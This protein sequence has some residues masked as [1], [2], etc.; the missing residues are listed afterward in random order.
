[1]LYLRESLDSALAIPNIQW[2][3]LVTVSVGCKL[4]IQ[5]FSFVLF[6][7]YRSLFPAFLTAEARSQTPT[8]PWPGLEKNFDLSYS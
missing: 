8:E 2:D 3:Y 6:H 5:T 1:M 7:C 4:S